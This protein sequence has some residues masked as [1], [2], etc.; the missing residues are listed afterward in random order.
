MATGVVALAVAWP[1]DGVGGPRWEELAGTSDLVSN[2][3]LPVPDKRLNL[4]KLNSGEILAL[5]RID[6]HSGCTVPWRPD[7]TFLD[8]TGWFRD[9][10]HAA[11]FDLTGRCFF[12]P[13]SRGLD[14]YPVRLRDG[15][16]EVDLEHPVE[17]PP[18]NEADAPYIP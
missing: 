4:V 11:T 12:G 3:P 9:P 14:R 18:F 13:C 7:F 16:V 5:S 6:P 2:Q 10:C 8:Q 1:S 17:G 15:R